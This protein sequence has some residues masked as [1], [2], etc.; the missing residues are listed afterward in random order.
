METIEAYLA[1]K[2]DELHLLNSCLKSPLDVADPMSVTEVIRYKFQITA[3]LRAEHA[4]HDW[5]TTE[6]AWSE[7][8]QTVGP[9]EFEYD[10]QR[11]DLKVDGPSFYGKERKATYETVY[12]ASGMAAIAALLLASAQVVKQA[13][14]CKAPIPRHWS[15]LN[16]TR[17]ICV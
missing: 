3:A 13:E 6:T 5:T 17:H 4:L 15:S 10:Y 2:R 1:R 14:S 12:T 11:A 9:F 16:D 7:N 8:P